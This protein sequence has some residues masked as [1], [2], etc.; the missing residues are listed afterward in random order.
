M[1]CLSLP[2]MHGMKERP[3]PSYVGDVES[4]LWLASGRQGGLRDAPSSPAKPT[5][6]RGGGGLAFCDPQPALVYTM[7]VSRQ[8]RKTHQEGVQY[9][10]LTDDFASFK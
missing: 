2:V 1:S 9:A 3:P 8:G 10:M 5:R 4:S 6:A 7:A